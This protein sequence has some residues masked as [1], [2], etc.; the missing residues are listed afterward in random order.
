MEEIPQHDGTAE[1]LERLLERW[2]TE[3]DR[4]EDFTDAFVSE[5]EGV[6]SI[7]NEAWMIRWT[8]G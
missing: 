3:P 1:E 7:Q 2:I 4:S 8:V 5:C 6:I